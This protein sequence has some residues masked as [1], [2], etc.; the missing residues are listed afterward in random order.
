MQ[1]TTRTTARERREG[2]RV[3][4]TR[5][6]WL[7]A[8]ALTVTTGLWAFGHVAELGSATL[9]PW[10]GL[11]QLVMLWSSSLAMLAILA[12]VRAQALEPLFGGLD[13]AVRLHRRLG[14]SALV[15]LVLHAAFLCA[16]A[17]SRG[18]SIAPVLS[19]WPWQGARSFDILA[20]YVLIGL[21]LLAYDKRL[22]HERWLALHRVIGVLFLLGTLHASIEP[23]T[24]HSFEPL[25]TWIVIL[26]LVGG[27]AGPIVSRCSGG[28]DRPIATRSRPWCRWGP[29]RSTWSCARSSDG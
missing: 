10:R 6:G 12:V 23:G 21:G 15:A 17:L 8:G 7:V 25:R 18:V 3:R 16:D 27:A 5:S 14:L 26:L 13:T 20:F 29:G 24:I 4:L 9:W 19:P 28:S 11:S 1:R 22:R 2:P